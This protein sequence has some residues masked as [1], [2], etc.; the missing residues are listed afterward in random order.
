MQLP[1]TFIDGTKEILAAEYP[2]LEEALKGKSPVSIRINKEKDAGCQTRERVAWCETGYY[3]ADRPLFTADPLF[4]AGCYY[5]QEASS[6]FLEQ[7]VKAIIDRPVVAL[8][9]CAAPGGKSTH[10]SALLPEGSLLLSNEIIRSRAYVLA[11]NLSKWGNPSHLVSN[12]EP[13]AI[14]Q[15]EEV[16]DLILADVPCSGEGMFRKDPASIA[17]WSPTNVAH[18]AER[19]RAIIQAVWPSLKPGG[20]LVYSTCTYNTAE[21]EENLAWIVEELGA[22]PIEIAIPDEWKISGSKKGDYPVY[23]FFPHLTRGEGFFLAVVQ[24]E[25]E[26]RATRHRPRKKDK[27]GKKERPLPVPEQVKTWL[28]DEKEFHFFIQGNEV[29]AIPQAHR[30]TIEQLSEQLRLIT[31]GLLLASIKGK[32]LIPAHH[33]AMSKAYKRE[34][35]PVYEAD[36]TTALQFLSKEAIILPADYPR[37]YVAISYQDQL[38]GFVKNIGN[39]ANNLYPQEWRI[40][41][42][43]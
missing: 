23:R 20:F 16:Y 8:D 36:K 17:E 35:F 33:L 26:E 31:P 29:L 19:Q 6:M 21:N 43:L 37:T 11:E 30:A 42:K 25:G 22:K 18:C 39:R 34:S 9:L 12:D 2:L 14:G 7:V 4:H 28:K 27:G 40:R 1:E 13:A 5:V 15:L 41:M 32:D 10:L 38:L 3:L 24:K